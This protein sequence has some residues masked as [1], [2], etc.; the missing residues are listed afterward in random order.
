MSALLDD[1]VD[2]AEATPATVKAPLRPIDRDG[3][4]VFAEKG[5][6]NPASRGTNKVRTVVDGQYRTLSYVG[7][8]APVVVDEPLHL[9]GQDTAPAPGEVALSALG[10]CLAVG[11][12]AVATWK[13][14]KLSKLEIFLEGD[15]GNPAAWGA[16][17]A[18]KLPAEMGFQAI[19]VK[20]EIEGDA[21]RELLDEI[22]QHANRYSPVANSMRNPI[23][24]QIALA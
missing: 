12:T 19:R 10:G 1:A 9:F 11:I 24:F 15:I 20:V 2:H 4:M 22:V 3:L 7:Q 8:H 18:E 14:V 13:Q 21:P 17:G 6:N 16:G 23:A 5:R